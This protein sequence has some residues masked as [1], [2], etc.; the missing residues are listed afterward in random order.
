MNQSK[1]FIMYVY[2]HPCSMT[3][4]KRQKSMITKPVNKYYHTF[5]ITSIL[6]TVHHLISSHEARTR[7]HTHTRRIHAHTRRYYLPLTNVVN[8]TVLILQ[9]LSLSTLI[10]QR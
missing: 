9:T 8:Y 5:Q 7:F 2:I 4:A 3:V 10:T 6:S 1:H